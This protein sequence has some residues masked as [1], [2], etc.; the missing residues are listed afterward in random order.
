MKADDTAFSGKV[1][2]VTGGSSGIG[3][4]LGVGL[5]RRGA[6]VWVVARRNGQLTAAKDKILSMSGCDQAAV[7]IISADI[8]DP[9]QALGCVRKVED[10]AGRIDYL[11]NSAG[12]VHPGY[13][14]DI[15]LELFHQ[16]M[17]VNYFG[18]VHMTKAVLPGMIQRR[19]GH[20]VNIASMGAVISYIG[21]SAYAPSKFAV[22]GF[23]DALR[24]EM[25]AYNVR[26]SI[27]YPGDTDTP[28]LDFENQFKPPETAALGGMGRLYTPDEVAVSILNG[29]QRGGYVIV[30]G[31]L[32]RFYY[33]AFVTL[34]EALNPIIDF[35]IRRSRKNME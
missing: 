18:T 3:L 14:Q 9:D 10:Q 31:S 4:S 27:V 28:Q 5:A 35:I 12:S 33:R 13:V 32:M 15:D 17:D 29:V 1:A 22:R 8:S 23:S 7:E 20:I 24:S 6:R 25:Q 11:F 16:M 26:V 34:G 19:S 21:Y 2:I 30:P